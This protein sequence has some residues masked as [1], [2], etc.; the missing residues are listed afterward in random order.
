M[1]QAR[2]YEWGYHPK[3][4]TRVKM[5]GSNQGRAR[6]ADLGLNAH[7]PF[8]LYEIDQAVVVTVGILDH[9]LDLRVRE[10]LA[11]ESRGE[12]EQ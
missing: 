8:E 4:R 10:F 7:H 5:K 9:V 6:D 3:D 11:Y 2:R 12:G 1:M